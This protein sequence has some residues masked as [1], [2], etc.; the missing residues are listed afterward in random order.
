[1]FDITKKTHKTESN[2]RITFMICFN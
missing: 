2:K 1:M